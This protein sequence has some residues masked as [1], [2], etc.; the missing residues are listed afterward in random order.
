[1]FIEK[2][3]NL[4]GH[5]IVIDPEIHKKAKLTREQ[6][7][8]RVSHVKQI[9]TSV[10][11]NYISF[12]I[13]SLEEYLN[14]KKFHELVNEAKFDFKNYFNFAIAIEPKLY[15]WFK[16]TEY[17]I[18]EKQISFWIASQYF[19][20]PD[21]RH[22]L[23]EQLYK[24]LFDEILKLV[25]TFYKDFE[26]PNFKRLNQKLLDDD[27]ESI[28]DEEER[29]RQKY[30]ERCKAFY[31]RN[32]PEF[33]TS[34]FGYDLSEDWGINDRY[35]FEFIEAYFLEKDWE[36]IIVRGNKDDMGRVESRSDLWEKWKHTFATYDQKKSPVYSFY[37]PTE[38][39]TKTRKKRETI[40]Q[41]VK[42]KVW[43]RD[44]GRCVQCG[45][46]E[47]LEFDHIIPVVKGGSSTYRN[48][49]LLCEPCNRTKHSKL[50]D[51]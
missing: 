34:P 3:K 31:K 28:F 35:C 41:D 43:K 46:N 47:K 24:P 16:N 4:S 32:P 36:N 38:T 29:C 44:E 18:I 15:D 19:F 21:K 42:D 39:E 9:R 27:D 49:Q 12:Y 5:L 51:T 33:L 30:L 13:C 26:L 17:S 50:G 6:F 25:D 14:L 22:I 1:M 20:V 37:Y 11:Y 10:N 23:T 40:P 8:D 7:L 2:D 45:S 48:V